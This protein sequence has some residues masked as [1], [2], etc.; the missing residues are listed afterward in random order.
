MSGAVRPM[1]VGIPSGSGPARVSTS[2]S[3]KHA[4]F[5]RNDEDDEYDECQQGQGEGEKEASLDRAG[6]QF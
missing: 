4:E 1:A 5:Y 2:S 3:T 6:L